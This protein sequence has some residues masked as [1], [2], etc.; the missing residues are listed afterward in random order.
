M[1]E[2]RNFTMNLGPQHPAAHGVLRQVPGITPPLRAQYIRVMFDEINPY[3][4]KI[5]A[6][7]FAHLAAIDEMTRGHMLTDEVAVI[8][9][10][11]VVCGE[12]DR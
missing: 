3:R 9:T 8:G 2:N 12:I 7:G 6:P 11:D 5:W 4:P 1:P 10:Q